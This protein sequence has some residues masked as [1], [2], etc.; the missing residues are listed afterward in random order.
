M[1]LGPGAGG[2]IIAYPP[3]PP[4]PLPPHAPSQA[5]RPAEK[6]RARH[7]FDFHGLREGGPV[8]IPSS[9]ECIKSNQQAD[10]F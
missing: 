9:A 1:R 8:T 10:H 6:K 4:T 3:L 5:K 7:A 2:F